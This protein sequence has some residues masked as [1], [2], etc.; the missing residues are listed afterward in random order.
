MQAINRSLF[1]PL[2]IDTNMG[3]FA[4]EDDWTQRVEQWV[5]Q[6]LM[7]SPGERINR[8]N[9]GCGVRRMVFAPNSEISVNLAQLTVY[10]ALEESLGEYI[11]VE[12]VTV[13]PNNDRLNIGIRYLLKTHNTRKHLNIEVTP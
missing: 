5:H 9:F 12:Q 8:P 2:Q 4:E 10:Q 11:D 1:Y 13:E 3:R 6:V 7:T